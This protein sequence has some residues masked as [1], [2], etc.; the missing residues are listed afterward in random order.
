MDL[1]SY[2]QTQIKERLS[3][4]IYVSPELD[5]VS[6]ELIPGVLTL[7]AENHQTTLET[8]QDSIVNKSDTEILNLPQIK[9][10]LDQSIEEVCNIYQEEFTKTTL[11]SNA[12]EVIKSDVTTLLK[13]SLSAWENLKEKTY[14]EVLNDAHAGS[15]E[16]RI[17][18]WLEEI[19]KGTGIEP[20]INETVD[21]FSRRALVH[22]L[23]TQK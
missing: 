18:L 7:L 5:V 1:F 15:N 13:G 10:I 20:E 19:K 8:L 17:Y 12:K 3:K 2:I 16:E 21:S 6:Q 23:R 22:F 11:E 4:G 14:Q 9:R